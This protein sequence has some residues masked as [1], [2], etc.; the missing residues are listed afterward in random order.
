MVVLSEPVPVVVGHGD[1]RL[2]RLRRRLAA[3]DRGVDVVD[4]L[5]GVGGQQVDRLGGVD[6]SSRRRRRRT[7]P[8]GRSPRAQSM[9]S[10]RLASVGSTWHAVVDRARRCRTGAIWSAIRCG[11]PVAATPG[12][13]T[14]STRRAPSW[15]EV[16]A[17]LVGRAGA[18]LQRGRAVGEDGLVHRFSSGVRPRASTA[19]GRGGRCRTGAARG[20]A[21]GAPRRWRGWCRPPRRRAAPRRRT[22][23]ARGRR[24]S[25]RRRGSPRPDRRAGRR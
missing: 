13:V 10:C 6:R 22:R 5:A 23:A 14:T 8:T 1:Q 17:D 2:Q 11:C 21:P 18:E 16:V 25:A 20:P 4:Q 7:R 12:S 24:R 3:A 15:A 19:R 9:A